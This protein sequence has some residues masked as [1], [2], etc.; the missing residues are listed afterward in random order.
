MV[1]V[2]GGEEL[3]PKPSFTGSWA[4]WEPQR[5]WVRSTCRVEEADRLAANIVW[6]AIGS[7]R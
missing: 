6:E 3:T 7:N 1:A 5:R 2:G 4:A